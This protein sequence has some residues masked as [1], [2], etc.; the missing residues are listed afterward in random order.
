MRSQSYTVIHL[1][2]TG[3]DGKMAAVIEGYIK[4]DIP[5]GYTFRGLPIG[6]VIR[7]DT[8]FIR[9]VFDPH[10]AGSINTLAQIIGKGAAELL[11]T[12]AKEGEGSVTVP[13]RE[14]VAGIGLL[15]NRIS[16]KLPA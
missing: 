7:D 2:Q 4:P 16:Q 9:I 14:V 11:G 6:V 5:N 3:D 1:E 10:T 15:N 8:S 13:R 12:Y